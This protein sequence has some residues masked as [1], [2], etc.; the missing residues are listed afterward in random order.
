MSKETDDKL[1]SGLFKEYR[2]MMFNIALGILHNK[3]DAEDV[4]QDAFLWIINNL[5]KTS[6]IPR[7]KMACYFATITEHRALNMV[8]RKR[9]HPLEDIDD[10]ETSSGKSIEERAAASITLDEIKLVLRE[11]SIND[12]LVLRMYLF[13]EKSYKEIAEIAGISE[14]AARVRV[15]RARKRLA[16]LLKERGIN[17]E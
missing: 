14:T 6:Q 1:I 12:R 8:N 15:S 11:M 16:K 9:T 5:E 17:Y 10:I 3:A 13:E 4:V 7:N 2:Q